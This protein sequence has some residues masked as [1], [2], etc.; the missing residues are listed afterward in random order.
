LTKKRIRPSSARTRSGRRPGLHVEPV[1]PREDE[2]LLGVA[3]ELLATVGGG[4]SAGVLRVPGLV[5][6]GM[7]V[8]GEEAGLDP[9]LLVIDP[10]M[11]EEVAFAR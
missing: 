6:V 8:P 7:E 11:V 1:L 10:E 4:E 2:G 3:R 5:T 9:V